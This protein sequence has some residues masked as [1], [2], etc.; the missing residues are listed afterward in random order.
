MLLVSSTCLFRL[1]QLLETEISD[2]ANHNHTQN[3]TQNHT[4]THADSPKFLEQSSIT[5]AGNDRVS[6]AE[7]QSVT[8]MASHSFGLPRKRSASLRDSLDTA[9]RGRGSEEEVMGLVLQEADSTTIE[10]TSQPLD[11]GEPP[12]L[13]ELNL[14]DPSHRQAELGEGP[15]K[16][17]GAVGLSS[18]EGCGDREGVRVEGSGVEGG[19]GNEAETRGGAVSAELVEESAAKKMKLGFEPPREDGELHTGL[20]ERGGE[21]VVEAS[22]KKETYKEEATGQMESGGCGLALQNLVGIECYGLMVY[23]QFLH[24]IT[25]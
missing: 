15:A 10:H 5:T 19:V 17:L 18:T 8:D 13:G 16:G 9:E 7:E 20:L 14:R 3:H 2:G 21:G 4:S 24:L 22:Q 12:E 6:P 1:T 11:I 23:R 25:I